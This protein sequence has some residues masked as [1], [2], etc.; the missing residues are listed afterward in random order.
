MK[1]DVKNKIL[2]KLD[3]IINLAEDN[4]LMESYP[5]VDIL[6]LIDN[7]FDKFISSLPSSQD[8]DRSMNN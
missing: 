7:E 5:T 4:D 6:E 8:T 3:G 2:E 1:E